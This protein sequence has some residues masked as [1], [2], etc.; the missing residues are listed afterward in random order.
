MCRV[1]SSDRSWSL[2]VL[3]K[4]FNGDTLP[5]EV[6]SA[7]IGNSFMLSSY[8]VQTRARRVPAKHEPFGRSPWSRFSRIHAFPRVTPREILRSDIPMYIRYR[9]AI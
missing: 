7:R 2:S 9:N 8:H 4:L 5:N 3:S 1:T 6:A